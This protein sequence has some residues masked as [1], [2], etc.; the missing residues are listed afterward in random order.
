MARLKLKGGA[1][2]L[3]PPTPT[4]TTTGIVTVTVTGTPADRHAITDR[5]AHTEHRTDRDRDD[6]PGLWGHPIH[7]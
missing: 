5:L 2:L 3:L 7:K 6:H 4:T 1:V